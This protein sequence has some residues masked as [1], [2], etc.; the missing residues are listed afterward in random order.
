MRFMKNFK[1]TKIRWILLAGLLLLVL[2]TPVLNACKTSRVR[3]N[4]PE[5][6]AR[7]FLEHLSMYEFDECR[8]LGN[9]N[10]DKM[11]DMLQVLMDLSKEKGQEGTFEKKQREITILKTAVDGKAAV[12]TYLDAN[13]KEQTLDLVR[14]DGKWLVDM[15]KEAPF[16]PQQ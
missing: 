6:V 12:V 14:E 1:V 16:K 9:A 2:T 13:G 8:E 11:I 5:S 10:T 7:R 15:K 3:A 4:T